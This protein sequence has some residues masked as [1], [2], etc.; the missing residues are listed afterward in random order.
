[1]G[2]LNYPMMLAVAADNTVSVADRNNNR[3][4]VIDAS[5]TTASEVRLNLTAGNTLQEPLSLAIDASRCRLYVGE[6]AGNNRIHVF[7]GI[8][9]CQNVPKLKPMTKSKPKS[10]S[11]KL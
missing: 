3:L 7:S 10:N 6:Y 1:M 11:T 5:L 8:V 4:V 2:Q 9:R